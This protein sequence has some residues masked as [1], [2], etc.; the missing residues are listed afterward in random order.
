MPSSPLD[1]CFPMSS[2]E[3]RTEHYSSLFCNVQE[4]AWHCRCSVN[5]FIK[6]WSANQ[7]VSTSVR[8]SHSLQV[9][10]QLHYSW[11]KKQP[12]LWFLVFLSLQS[13][14]QV[15]FSLSYILQVIL[16][17]IFLNWEII[18]FLFSPTCLYLF[19]SL[20]ISQTYLGMGLCSLR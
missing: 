17:V 18:F 13:H 1:A 5:V 9:S 14:P 12:S 16:Y 10:H 4:S 7:Y 8:C 11:Q 2:S 6:V 19:F 20:Q 15:F 3:T